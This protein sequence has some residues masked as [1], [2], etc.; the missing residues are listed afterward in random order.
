[1]IKYVEGNIFEST[2]EVIVNPINTV[3]VMGKGLALKFKINY[4][5]MFKKYQ[6]ICKKGLLKPGTLY[7]HTSE[8]KKILLFPT[9]KHW[10]DN[11]KVKYVEKSKSIP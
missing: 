11:S 9:K 1:M 4:P 7:L 8:N 6:E 5:D 3:G 2:A 10:K